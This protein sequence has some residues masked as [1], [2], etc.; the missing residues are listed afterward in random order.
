MSTATSP[1]RSGRRGPH[2]K[3]TRYDIV[4]SILQT[5]A[6]CAGLT[7]MVMLFIWLSNLLPTPISR[8]IEMMAG[9][10][11]WEDGTPDASPNVE[12][13]EDAVPDPSVS[14][15]ETDVTQLEE[16]VEQVVEIAENAAVIEAPNEFTQQNNSGVPGSAE[17]TGG[18]PLG[19]GGPGRGGAKR[20]NGWFV[21]FADKGDLD[22][23]AQQLDFFGIELGLLIKEES[24]LV[25]LSGVSKT[26]PTVREVRNG[27]GEKRLFMNWQ[28]GSQERMKAD[29]E[30]FQ[31]AGIDA[32]KGAI[33]HFYPPAT[34]Q[35]LA[36]LETS[37]ANQPASAIR[38]TTFQVQRAG[39]GFEFV[40][41]RQIL[42]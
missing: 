19:S 42:K 25:Y 17:G 16:V 10:G 41:S 12:S 22:S 18:R 37:Y 29:I 4:V 23:Y 14:N 21:E 32:S 8:K 38:R 27:E 7:F 6:L 3:L 39:N 33:L 15:E 13:P 26:P 20:E 34:E 11:G 35:I 9:D 40:V 1:R 28:D 30:L 2:I 36:Q 31:R 5:S 24:R